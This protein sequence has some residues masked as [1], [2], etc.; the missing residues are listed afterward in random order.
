MLKQYIGDEK[1]MVIGYMLYNSMGIL[2]YHP[3][4]VEIYTNAMSSAHKNI[5]NYHLTRANLNLTMK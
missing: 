4:T 3:L 1:G 2:N 5:E